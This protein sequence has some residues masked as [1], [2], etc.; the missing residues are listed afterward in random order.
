MSAMIPCLLLFAGAVLLLVGLR[1]M[2]RSRR[3]T[4]TQ[5]PGTITH[6]EVG[7]D[8]ELYQPLVRYEYFFNSRSY[9]GSTIR[10]LLL[11]YN[12]SGP[13]TRM[14]RR[15]PVGMQVPI[16]VDPN[17]PE[18]GVLETSEDRGGRMVIYCTSVL[19]ILGGL[20]LL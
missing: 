6:S 8:G 9:T 4:W 12:W 1:P 5:V 10:P 18:A 11:Q 15:Y 3:T 16:Y 13:A 14:C 2:Q 17:R 7:F 19:L 20:L